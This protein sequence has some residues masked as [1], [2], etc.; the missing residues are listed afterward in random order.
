MCVTSVCIHSQGRRKINYQDNLTISRTFNFLPCF[1]MLSMPGKF[2]HH[3]PGFFRMCKSPDRCYTQ[4]CCCAVCFDKKNLQIKAN[5][6]VVPLSASRCFIFFLRLTIFN[7]TF[8]GLVTQILS[9][10]S[11]NFT[12]VFAII[13]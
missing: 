7:E 12:L 10:A 2:L 4:Y 6:H 1:P 11:E 3:C 8:Q 13:I 9:N 5:T